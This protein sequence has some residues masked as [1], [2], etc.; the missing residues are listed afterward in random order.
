MVTARHSNSQKVQC[1]PGL[2]FLLLFAACLLLLL[3]PDIFSC[4][5]N[6]CKLEK[7]E[8]KR[9]RLNVKSLLE[10][11]LAQATCPKVINCLKVDDLFLTSYLF[12]SLCS[13][14]I[15]FRLHNVARALIP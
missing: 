14:G 12:L 3:E 1:G 6:Y 9:S 5:Q 4:F 2:V 7:L 11:E 13:Q 10:R 8:K 15:E